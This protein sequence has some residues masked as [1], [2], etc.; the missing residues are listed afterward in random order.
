MK[1]DPENTPLRDELT[2]DKVLEGHDY[3]GIKELDNKLPKW[4]VGLFYITIIFALVYVLRFHILKTSPLQEEEYRIEMAAA[5]KKAASVAEQSPGEA[6]TMAGP[7][8][9]ATNLDAGKAVYDK[10]CAVCHLAEGQGL[11]GPNLTDAYWIH[12]GSY[13]N[14]VNIIDV[15]VIEKGMIAWKDMLT[16]TEVQQVASFIMSLQGTDPPNPKA[17]EGD[18]YTPDT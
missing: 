7:L 5:E 3:D 1:E 14:I 15:G 17:P 6:T 2:G 10:H 12:G 13:E 8:A 11:V 18:L 4:W 9:D 16:P